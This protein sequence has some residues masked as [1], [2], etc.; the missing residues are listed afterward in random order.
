MIVVAPL[1]GLYSW[2]KPTPLSSYGRGFEYA[3]HVNMRTA[4]CLLSFSVFGVVMWAWGSYGDNGNAMELVMEEVSGLAV[5]CAEQLGGASGSLGVALGSIV[6]LPGQSFCTKGSEK[7]P[8]ASTEEDCET[9]SSW[10]WIPVVNNEYDSEL[11]GEAIVEYEC[12]ELQKDKVT[13]KLLTN[14]VNCEFNDGEWHWG[15]PGVLEGKLSA[16]P[17]YPDIEDKEFGFCATQIILFAKLSSMLVGEEA[18]FKVSRGE[19]EER[20]GEVFWAE[21]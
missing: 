21:K 2:L 20:K 19:G 14:E 3:T 10:N 17:N 6:V 7:N 18:A 4:L 11:G 13:S 12:W 15:S 8:T 9:S 1:M 5:Y 16:C